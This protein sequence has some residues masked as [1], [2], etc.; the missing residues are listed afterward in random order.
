[1]INNIVFPKYIIPYHLIC[2]FALAA[3]PIY[4]SSIEADLSFYGL[5]SL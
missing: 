5:V 2:D 1:M 4:V 3:R